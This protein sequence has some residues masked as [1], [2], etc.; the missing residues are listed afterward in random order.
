MK[1]SR[2]DLN[3]NPRPDLTL[4]LLLA[5]TLIDL[6]LI[7]GMFKTPN[8]GLTY[9]DKGHGTLSAYKVK[10]PGQAKL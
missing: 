10:G 2:P 3:P 8:S 1:V 7:G 5:L 6:T 4:I 9:F